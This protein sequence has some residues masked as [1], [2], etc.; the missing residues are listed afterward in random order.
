[1]IDNFSSAYFTICSANYL[2]TAKI[3]IDT[4]ELNTDRDTFIIICDKK[5]EKIEEFFSKNR[6][7]V[8]FVEDLK[9][10]NFD[11]FILRY[12]ILEINTAIKPFVFN[13]LL[14]NL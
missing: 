7:K 5:Q 6:V 10:K 14:G 11:R 8:I 2:P 1:M 13:H 9:I 12:S 4:L 3:L